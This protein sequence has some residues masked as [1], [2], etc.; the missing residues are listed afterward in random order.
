M[1]DWC[2]KQ[3]SVYKFIPIMQECPNFYKLGMNCTRVL[4]VKCSLIKFKYKQCLK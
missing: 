2:L 3:S 4:I 1:H